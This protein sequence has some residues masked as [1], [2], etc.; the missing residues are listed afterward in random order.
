MKKLLFSSFLLF[1]VLA[2]PPV[3]HA[4][5]SLPGDDPGINS[6]TG[7]GDPTPGTTAAEAMGRPFGGLDVFEF[8]CTCS[9]FMY[10]V[11][12]PLYLSA[13]PMVGALATPDSPTMFPYY[14]L[15]PSAWA[16]GFF[17]PGVPACWMYV[18]WGCLPI[19]STL[20]VMTPFT[21]TSL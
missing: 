6:A 9:P 13:I 14:A 10:T 19:L 18:G 12:A 8:P 21:G 20:G 7:T 3:S 5:F 1:F 16:L 17:T 11:F 15:F 2:L 4:Q